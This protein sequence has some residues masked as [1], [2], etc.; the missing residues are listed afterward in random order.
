MFTHFFNPVVRFPGTI[1]YFV[2]KP[3]QDFGQV[4]L[5]IEKGVA[6]CEA[7]YYNVYGAEGHATLFFSGGLPQKGGSDM[8][9]NLNKAFGYL[10]TAAAIIAILAQAGK[11]VMALCKAD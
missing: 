2:C 4:R 11:K 9:V 6:L 10:E 1:I 8:R 5:R 3:V 7:L